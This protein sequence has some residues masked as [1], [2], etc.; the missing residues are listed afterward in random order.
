MSKEV[1]KV[2]DLGGAEAVEVIE[3]PVAA[4][5]SV[6]VDD[7][8]VVL[9]SDKASMDVPS[10]KAGNVVAILI[11]EGDNLSEGD[12][13]LEIE[14]AGAGDSEEPAEVEQQPP[15]AAPEPAVEEPAAEPSAGG[16]VETVNIP[17]IGT[18]DE[19]DVVEV[20][21]ATGDSIEEGDTILVLESDKSSMEVPSPVGGKVESVLVSEGAKVK[22]GTPVVTV[23]TAAPS[24]QTSAAPAPSEPSPAAQPAATPPPKA[25]AAQQPAAEPKTSGADVYAGPAVR[26][27]AR[28]LGVDLN[29]VTGTGPRNRILKEDVNNFVKQAL[30]K[31]AAAA[32]GPG[33]GIPAIPDLDFSQFGPVEEVELSKIARLTAANMSRNWLNVPAV[34]QF[35]DADITEMEAFRKGLKAESEKRGIKLTP[36][37]FLVLACAKALAAN[38][39][40]NRSWHSSGEKVIQKH[41]INIGMAVDTPRGLLV[42][43]VRD[44]DKKGLWELAEDINTLA[45]KAR[46]GKLSAAEMQGGCFSISSLGALGGTGFTPIVNAPEAAI[47]GVSKASTKPVWNGGE[48]V[49]RQMLPLSLTYDHKLINGGDAGRFM[50]YLVDVIGDLWRMLL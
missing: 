48:F 36:M 8:L 4:G 37:P 5:D 3:I 14:T 31:P 50:T 41:F 33:A 35:D 6:E 22:T 19:V 20:S 1:I 18:D 45:G 24:S 16:A 32:A 44:A 28:E 46:D 40:F 27:L 38:P 29:S 25:A 17:D 30:Q 49:P 43:V 7:T 23:H 2:P 34:T 26:Q 13:I 39:V 11:K 21:V 12:P 15:A 9:E 42:P 47:L 10:T